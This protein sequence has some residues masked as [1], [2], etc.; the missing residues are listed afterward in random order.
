MNSWVQYKW[1]RT[2]QNTW[3]KKSLPR[4]LW[5]DCTLVRGMHQLSQYILDQSLNE[6]LNSLR[7]QWLQQYLMFWPAGYC[8]SKTERCSRRQFYSGK[9]KWNKGRQKLL[10]QGSHTS[11]TCFIYLTEI[12]TMATPFPFLHFYNST[13]PGKYVNVNMTVF[14]LFVRINIFSF[15]C[16]PIIATVNKKRGI[17]FKLINSENFHWVE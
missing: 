10:E 14:L 9:Y 4:W 15:S 16:R 8:F 6:M 17:N 13:I 2:L 5:C 1:C 3:W 12:C 11:W 7:Y